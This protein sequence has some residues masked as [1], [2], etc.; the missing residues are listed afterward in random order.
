MKSSHPCPNINKLVNKSY[1]KFT[2]IISPQIQV[3]FILEI[4]NITYSDFKG[5]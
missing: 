3:L 5:P 1:I 4:L 2:G